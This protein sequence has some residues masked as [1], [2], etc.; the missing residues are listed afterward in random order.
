MPYSRS[1]LGI[2]EEQ[3]ARRPVQLECMS[4]QGVVG[5]VNREVQQG[6]DWEG[7]LRSF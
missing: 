4:K 3:T 6:L 5:E 2:Y 1:I 7:S